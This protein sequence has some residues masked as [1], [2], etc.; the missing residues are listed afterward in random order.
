MVVGAVEEAAKAD[1]GEGKG[2]CGMICL[3]RGVERQG[4][5]FGID[6]WFWFPSPLPPLRSFSFLFSFFC[7]CCVALFFM[8]GDSRKLFLALALSFFTHH[9]RRHACA[10][11][12]I[13]LGGA[14]YVCRR[15][16]MCRLVVQ[17][18]PDVLAMGT[19]G[20]RCTGSLYRRHPKLVPAV[21]YVPSDLYRQHPYVR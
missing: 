1:G 10:P 17:A 18:V 21:S 8:G 5:F 9:V 15:H 7:F 13:V 14:G 4:F 6:F 2:G 19:V 12:C 11:H 16:P 3:P 20:T